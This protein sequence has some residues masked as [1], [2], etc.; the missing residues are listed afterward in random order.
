MSLQGARVRPLAVAPIRQVINDRAARPGRLRGARALAGGGCGC[1]PL[2]AWGGFTGPLTAAAI[3]AIPTAAAAPPPMSMV[4]LQ[5]LGG[6]VERVSL[7]ATAVQ[8]PDGARALAILTLAWPAGD[9]AEQAGWRGPIPHGRSHAIGHAPDEDRKPRHPQLRPGVLGE[10]RQD[11][12][13]GRRRSGSWHCGARRRPG[14][15]WRQGRTPHGLAAQA[16]R[17]VQSRC[18]PRGLWPAGA[19]SP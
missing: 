8:H 12:A 15:G 3:D 17:R 14:T 4:E 6:A 13:M 10:Q 7:D 19:K 5:P 9:G 11:G 2:G 18:G 1:L 16:G